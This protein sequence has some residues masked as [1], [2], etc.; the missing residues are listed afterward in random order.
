MHEL[1]SK[2]CINLFLNDRL[3]VLVARVDLMT[4][5]GGREVISM[6]TGPFDTPED[7]LATILE[8]LEHA[9]DYGQQLRL[10]VPAHEE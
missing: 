2:W 1:V 9:E 8:L 6:L 7:I 5:Q 4:G 10:P 3:E